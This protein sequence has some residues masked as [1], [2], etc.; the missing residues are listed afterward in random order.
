M[1]TAMERPAVGLGNRMTDEGVEVAEN[2]T[3]LENL[4][5]KSGLSLEEIVDVISGEM[6]RAAV[7][8]LLHRGH[9]VAS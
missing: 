1:T 8:E 4:M 2:L 9:E 7:N 5:R 3:H 6:G